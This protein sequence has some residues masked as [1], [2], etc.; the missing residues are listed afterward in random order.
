MKKVLIVLIVLL[1][2]A[3]GAAWLLLDTAVA[4]SVE[5]GGTYALEVPTTVGG[6][7]LQ[8]FAGE[9][10]VD[11]LLVANPAGF[12]SPHF[13]RLTRA[14][15]SADAGTLFSDRVQIRAIGLAGLDVHLERGKGG[16]NAGKILDSLKRFEGKPETEKAPEGDAKKLVI[17]ELVLRD[18]TVHSHLVPELGE[19]ADAT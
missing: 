8:P 1:V 19:A 5:K 15:A 9:I 11:D 4:K 2:L 14:E 10:G 16:T 18:I 3:V 17:G 12:T 6:A 7:S 13:L